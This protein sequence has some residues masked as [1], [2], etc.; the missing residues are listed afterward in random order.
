MAHEHPFGVTG[1]QAR[2]MDAVCSTGSHKAAARAL[3]ITPKTVE[4]HCA[5]A[6]ERMRLRGAISPETGALGKYLAWDR[7]R[8]STAKETGHG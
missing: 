8:R 6:G 7:H 1:A 5:A 3:G 4:V 2:A